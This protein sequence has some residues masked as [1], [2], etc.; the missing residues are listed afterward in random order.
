MVTSVEECAEIMGAE[1]T[2]TMTQRSTKAAKVGEFPGCQYCERSMSHAEWR[3]FGSCWSCGWKKFVVWCAQCDD[4]IRLVTDSEAAAKECRQCQV[5]VRRSR[6]F[7]QRCTYPHT[8]CECPKKQ[9]EIDNGEPCRY[10]SCSGCGKPRERPREEHAFKE[11]VC[12]SCRQ[13]QGVRICDVCHVEKK[14]EDYGPEKWHHMKSDGHT[15]V[16]LHCAAMLECSACKEKHAPEQLK[17]F[18]KGKVHL[19][20]KCEGNGYGPRALETHQCGHCSFAGGSGKF[21]KKS[22]EHASS[23][24]T[25]NKGLQCTASPNLGHLYNA[26]AVSPFSDQSVPASCQGDRGLQTAIAC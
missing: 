9:E 5:A 13:K 2:S 23:A 12:F 15:A 24:G 17:S 18:A 1:S 11:Y 14:Q 19:C 6:Y 4:W 16:C 10:P 21:H 3:R 25:P 22:I 7:C 20:G 8:Q 26:P